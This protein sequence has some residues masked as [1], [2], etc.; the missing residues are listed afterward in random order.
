MRNQE[1]KSKEGEKKEGR[2]QMVRSH[3]KKKQDK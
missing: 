2:L 1:K 3:G